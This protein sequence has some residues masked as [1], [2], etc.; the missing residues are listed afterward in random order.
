[1]I[2]ETSYGSPMVLSDRLIVVKFLSILNVQHCEIILSKILESIKNYRRLQIRPP[3][4]QQKKD[5]TGGTDP[6]DE[7]SNQLNIS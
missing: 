2:R 5:A 3:F 1:M 6:S 7:D 4:R